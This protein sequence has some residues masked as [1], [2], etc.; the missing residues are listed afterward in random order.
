MTPGALATRE[1]V[2]PAHPVEFRQVLVSASRAG[3][4]GLM[5]GIVDE[6]A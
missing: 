2:R 5:S 1:R 3:T 4:A 6:S